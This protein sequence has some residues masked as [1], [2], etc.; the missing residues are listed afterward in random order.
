M[1][2]AQWPGSHPV[3][4]PTD[5]SLVLQYRIV[6]HRGDAKAAQIDRLQREYEKENFLKPTDRVK[7]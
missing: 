1:Q 3:A 5:K 4:V 2:N 7:R 6:I